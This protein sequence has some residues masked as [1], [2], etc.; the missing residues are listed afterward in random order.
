[1]WKWKAFVQQKKNNIR[2]TTS[3]VQSQMRNWKNICNLHKRQF[4]NPV[5]EE[6]LKMNE[7]PIPW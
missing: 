1:M 5:Y 4:N 2:H 6:Y 3:K 7:R